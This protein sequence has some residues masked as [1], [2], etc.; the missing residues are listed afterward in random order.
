M[1]NF[2]VACFF[3]SME[4]LFPSSFATGLRVFTKN[5][6]HQYN[7]VYD[8]RN[9]PSKNFCYTTSELVE[10]LKKLGPNYSHFDNRIVNSF[11]KIYP[12]LNNYRMKKGTMYMWYKHWRIVFVKYDIIK[13]L[14]PEKM[15]EIEELEKVKNVVIKL[16][17]YQHISE[18][19]KNRLLDL[20]NSLKMFL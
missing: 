10:E 19:A 5:N 11:P 6:T 8:L 12:E 9:Q 18:P 14:I 4:R 16:Y 17:N 2:E 3:F 20:L 13:I 7:S 1:Y 15:S